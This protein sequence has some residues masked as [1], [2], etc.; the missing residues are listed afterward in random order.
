MIFLDCVYAF[1]AIIL[2]N[3]LVGALVTS[4]RLGRP[5]NFPRYWKRW[6]RDVFCSCLSL[7]VGA[8]ERA[9]AMALFIWAPST[10]LA[11]I[12]GWMALKYAAGWHQIYGNRGREETLIALIGSAWS[13]SIAVGAA[14][15]IHPQS[16]AHF[17]GYEPL[18]PG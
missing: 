18:G 6:R 9:I 3:Y 7:T 15:L 12:G 10:L 1:A 2:A 16:L 14:Y 8:T 5:K 4:L 11:F 13:L 17:T